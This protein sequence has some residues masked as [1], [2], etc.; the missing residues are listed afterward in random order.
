MP[1]IRL[2]DS[3]IDHP[4]FI[5]LSDRAFRLWHEGMAYCR[6]HQTD[7]LIP[8]AAL[9]GFRYASKREVVRELTS[10]AAPLWE[11]VETVGYR[12]HDYLEWNLPRDEEQRRSADSRART[13][14][15]RS[16]ASRD[17]SRDARVLDRMGSDQSSSE[18]I[19]GKPAPA[20]SV[21]NAFRGHWKQAYGYDCSLLIKPLEYMQLE[22]QLRKNSEASLLQAMRAYFASA[23]QFVTRAKHP[24]PL[25]LRDPMR[26]LASIPRQ[27]KRPTGC[28]HEP[29]CADAVAHTDRYRAEIRGEGL[30]A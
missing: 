11:T 5:V 20:E 10:P 27:N 28:R 14:K 23:D 19:Q 12:V 30:P 22:E 2:S 16:N 29:P 13:R 26:Y 24:L 18:G 15:W 3:Y 1:F 25:F 21:V 17:T 8:S 6:K 7:G 4:K 9:Q